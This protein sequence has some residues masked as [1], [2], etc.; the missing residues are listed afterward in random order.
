MLESFHSM[1]QQETE[2]MEETLSVKL[3]S[4]SSKLAVDMMFI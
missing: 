4:F 3:A 2:R 1:I